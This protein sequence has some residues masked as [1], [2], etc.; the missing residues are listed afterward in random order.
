MPRLTNSVPKYR[1]HKASGQ[2][3]VTLDGQDFYLGA[4]DSR[5]SRR[6]YDR[7]VGEWQQNGRRLPQTGQH[8]TL[9]MAILMNA[10]RTFAAGYYV[11]HGRQ[12]DTIYG[13]KAMLKLV[14]ASYLDTRVSWHFRVYVLL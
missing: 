3:I 1:H 12:T 13:I 9:T 6:E 14:R 5:P 2:A 10:Y 4:Y 7:L 8:N 11:K